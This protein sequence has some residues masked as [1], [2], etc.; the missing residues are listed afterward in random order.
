MKIEVFNFDIKKQILMNVN[1]CIINGEM[2]A[3]NICHFD[4]IFNKIS[5]EELDSD[6][7]LYKIWNKVKAYVRKYY[8]INKKK[9]NEILSLIN[10]QL[11]YI[12]N[13]I[14]KNKSLIKI[15]EENDEK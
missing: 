6:M 5:Y 3:N 12:E 13:S 14:G 4:R 15:K 2:D 1:N 9:L 11:I 8:E 7:F 10:E